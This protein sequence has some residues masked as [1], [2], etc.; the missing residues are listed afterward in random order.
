MFGDSYSSW[1][2]VSQSWGVLKRNKTLVVFPILSGIACLFV[3]ASFLAPLVLS[4]EIRRVALTWFEDE[5][6]G[7]LTPQAQLGLTLGVFAFYFANYFVIV[8]CNTALAA[9]ALLSFEGDE[10][11]VGT[12]LS[13]A[14]A[15]LPHILG[16]SLLAATVG[17]I[18]KAIEERADLVG[19]IV[20]GLI[21]LAWTAATALVVP[22]L[23]VEKLGPLDAVKRSTALLKDCWGTGLRGNFRLGLTGLLINIP[24]ALLIVGGFMLGTEYN[25]IVP[26]LVGGGLG[27]AYLLAAAVVLT[28]VKQIFLAGLYYYAVQRKVPAGFTAEAMKGAFRRK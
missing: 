8:F 16:W 18:L 12:G 13:I 17:M 28:T 27:F 19:S 6:N 5:A 7:N 23:V 2:I 14:T 25:S 24:G 3:A 26:V 20:T 11:T 15:R 4:P 9:C 22:V 21:G 10:P 1:S